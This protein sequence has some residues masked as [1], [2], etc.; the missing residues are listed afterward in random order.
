[1][2][3]RR[4]RPDAHGVEEGGRR[5]LREQ[6]APDDHERRVCY[7]DVFLRAPEDDG[8]RGDGDAAGKEVRGHVGDEEGG[9]RGEV[10]GEF[11]PVDGFVVAVVEE[12]GGWAGGWVRGCEGP[13]RRGGYGAEFAGVGFA[14]VERDVDVVGAEGG[15]QLRGFLRR[16]E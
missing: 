8:V 15:Q 11:H 6:V 13:A 5:L 14:G 9:G 16:F 7:A 1:M 2:Q 3:D 10:G 4:G 12:G